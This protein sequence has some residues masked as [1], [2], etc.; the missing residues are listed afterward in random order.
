M[1]LPD[2]S[3]NIEAACI[4]MNWGDYFKL[5]LENP[6]GLFKLVASLNLTDNLLYPFCVCGSV[7]GVDTLLRGI[8]YL[9]R[10]Q[11][12]THLMVV[13]SYDGDPYAATKNSLILDEYL[14]FIITDRLDD[15]NAAKEKSK[16]AFGNVRYFIDNPIL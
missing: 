7:K 15:F 1:M 13:N 3:G 11:H 2:A 12:Q 6:K 4:A 10:T 9:F 5:A 8:A 16:D 14:F